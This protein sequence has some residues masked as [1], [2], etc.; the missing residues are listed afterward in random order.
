LT[1][2]MCKMQWS[3]LL[4]KVISFFYLLFIYNFIL[5]FVLFQYSFYFSIDGNV[6][7]FQFPISSWM[8]SYFHSNFYFILNF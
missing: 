4:Q 7:S 2:L 3:Y 5:I 1:C 8:R 6:F